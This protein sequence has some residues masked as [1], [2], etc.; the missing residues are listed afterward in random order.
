MP[1]GLAPVRFGLRENSGGGAADPNIGGVGAGGDMTAP[2]RV[3][4]LI[5]PESVMV[6]GV[7][8]LKTTLPFV[9]PIVTPG[10]ATIPL[11]PKKTPEPLLLLAVTVGG[12]VPATSGPSGPLVIT[13]LP[14]ELIGLA[15]LMAPAKL[16]F[17]IS[18][19][20]AAVIAVPPAKLFTKISPKVVLPLVSETGPC[21]EINE[22]EKILPLLVNEKP[23]P[24][25]MLPSAAVVVELLIVAAPAVLSVSV[26]GVPFARIFTCS[27]EAVVPM[28]PPPVIFKVF[29]FIVAPGAWVMPV[30]DWMLTVPFAVNAVT[31]GFV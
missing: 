16:L 14:M 1:N 30:L 3:L 21:E 26:P 19:L 29:A 9:A 7:A 17:W 28:L 18:K 27:G 24:V 2:T 13:V 8:P 20:P 25:W 31:V 15:M 6:V 22:F 4:I 23:L 12:V 5:P 10:P 11:V